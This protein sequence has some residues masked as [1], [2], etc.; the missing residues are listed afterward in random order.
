MTNMF[1]P[2]GILFTGAVP[3][4]CVLVFVPG[5]TISVKNNK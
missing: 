4:D 1:C 3:P 2:A 5:N